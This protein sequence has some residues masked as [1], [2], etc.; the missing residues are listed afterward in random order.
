MQ[1]RSGHLETFDVTKQEA[2]RSLLEK[3]KTGDKLQQTVK[4]TL[5]TPTVKIW[6]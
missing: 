5:K 4:G 3:K 1:P 2:S 6:N